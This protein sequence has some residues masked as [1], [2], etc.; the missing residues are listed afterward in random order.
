MSTPNALMQ[1]AR[2]EMPGF[3]G[4]LTGPEDPGYDEAR[5]VYNA[6]IDR[7]PGAD[8]DAAPTP[9]TSRRS[10][11]FAARPRPACWPSAA[12]ATTAPGWAPATTA[13]S[14]TSRA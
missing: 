2:S 9:T 6:M 12:A 13:S 4:S 14:S 3:Q 8:R 10:S 7:R 11:R 1:T 5:K